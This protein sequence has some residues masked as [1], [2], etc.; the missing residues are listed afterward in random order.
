MST[1]Q[2]YLNRYAESHQNHSNVLINWICVPL[3]VFSL[4]GL[5]WAI[6]VPHIAI[7]GKLN[8]YVN[9]ATLL[10]LFATVYYLRLSFRIGIAMILT[11][12][13]FSSGIILLERLARL[14]GWP[15]MW[16]VCL[17]IFV[18]AWVAQ[19]IGPLLKN[20]AQMR[21]KF[22]VLFLKFLRIIEKIFAYHS[23]EFGIAGKAV[24]VYI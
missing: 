11:I 22:R 17:T 9:L 16:Q 6:P 3:I 21:I 5:V 2:H 15:E 19:F 14:H 20:G 13:I 24:R 4:L 7:L 18:L 10:I 1:L 12:C 23:Q 8:G